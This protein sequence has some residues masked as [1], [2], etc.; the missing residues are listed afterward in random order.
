MYILYHIIYMYIAKCR[1]YIY[2]YIYTH[3][4]IHCL[5]YCVSHH[6]A[7]LRVEPQKAKDA[8]EA[9]QPVR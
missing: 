7:E 5:T 4:Y 3:R 6:D 9:E 8:H 1:F 2:I